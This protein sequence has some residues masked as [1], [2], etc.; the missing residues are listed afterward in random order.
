MQ[1]LKLIFFSV[2]LLIIASACN[3]NSN[4]T[5]DNQL[6]VSIL[7]QQYLVSTIAGSNFD[8]QCLLPPGSNHET[9][10]PAPRDLEKVSSASVYFILGAL[11]FELT[12]LDRFKAAN[13]NLSV[14]NTGEGITFSDGHIHEHDEDHEITH[15]HGIDPHTWLS[16]ACMKIQAANIYKA[17]SNKWPEKSKEFAQNLDKFNQIADLTDSIIRQKLDAKRGS[18]FLIFHPALGY[19][20][21]DYNLNQISI[22]QE[23]KEPS[24]VYMKQII[25]NSGKQK[26]KIILVSKESDT[27]IAEAISKET[28]A[29]IVVYDPMS[30]DWSNNLIALADTLASN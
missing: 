28:G 17:L 25:E 5:N 3:A 19:F 10:E 14:V 16:P 15:R 9:Y 4:K 18:S 1:K 13:P 22:E 7:P 8:V 11:D 6:V 30:T 24:A 12:W 29:R 26:L 23:G 27:R 2:L 20:A 21:R